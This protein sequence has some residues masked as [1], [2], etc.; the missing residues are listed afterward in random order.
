[1]FSLRPGMKSCLF[2]ALA[3]FVFLMGVFSTI[4][5]VH[6]IWPLVMTDTSIHATRIPS[7]LGDQ[8]IYANIPFVEHDNNVV[9]ATLVCVSNKNGMA[10]RNFI[11]PLR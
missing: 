4:A 1:M 10:L 2:S 9:G 3:V 11:G 6:I 5:T 7:Y 8:R